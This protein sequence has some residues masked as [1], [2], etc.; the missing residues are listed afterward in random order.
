MP[1]PPSSS[2]SLVL[3]NSAVHDVAHAGSSMR[4]EVESLCTG[5]AVNLSYVRSTVRS[6]EM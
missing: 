2:L 4:N 3:M 1:P 5:L 6:E